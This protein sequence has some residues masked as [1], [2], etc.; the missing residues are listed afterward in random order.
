MTVI[1]TI[2]IVGVL[3]SSD[4]GNN[5]CTAVIVIQNTCR[6]TQDINVSYGKI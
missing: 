5:I 3:L 4:Y 1:I 2:L 6:K